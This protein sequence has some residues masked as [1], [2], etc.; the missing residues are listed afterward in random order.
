MQ[1]KQSVPEFPTGLQKIGNL[2][3]VLNAHKV[4]NTPAFFSEHKQYMLYSKKYKDDSIFHHKFES[5]IGQLY[6]KVATNRGN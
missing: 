3:E 2:T 6:L 4:I 5:T 1:F